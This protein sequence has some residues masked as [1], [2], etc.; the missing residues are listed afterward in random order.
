MRDWKSRGFWVRIYNRNRNVN[1]KTLTAAKEFSYANTKFF[2]LAQ[3]F[4]NFFLC[5][6]K[7]SG[8]IIINITMVSIIKLRK[9]VVNVK[10][11]CSTKSDVELSQHPHGMSLSSLIEGWTFCGMKINHNKS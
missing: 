5:Y 7:I 3:D 6:L 4:L 2:V 10:V 11:F 9:L 1:R 8:K